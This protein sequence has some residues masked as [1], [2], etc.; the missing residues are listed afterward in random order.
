M[1][2]LFVHQ[3]FPAQF[4]HIARHLVQKLGWRCAFV[5]ETPGGMVE[6]IDKIQYKIAG[7]ARETTHFC[8]RTFENAVWHTDA[9]LQAVKGRRDFKPDLIVG[10]SGFG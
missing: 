3:N 5:S 1:N 4:G 10:H 9:V 8:S 2:L 7:G 6:G